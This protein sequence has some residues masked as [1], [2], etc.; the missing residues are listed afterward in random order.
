M[1][2][3]VEGPPV[4]SSRAQLTAE[5]AAL[6][7]AEIAAR[8]HGML[9][10]LTKNVEAV[11]ID[12]GDSDAG[13]RRARELA[14][15]ATDLVT[16]LERAKATVAEH[17]SRVNRL[18]THG[19]AFRATLGHA[20]DA[21]SRDRSRERAHIDAIAARQEGIDADATLTGIDARGRDAL[22][23]EQAALEAEAARAQIV[24]H[25][26]GFQI[27]ALQR[28]LAA[29]NEQLDGE[30]ADATGKLEGALSALRRMTGELIRTI[31]EAA[32][33]VS[34]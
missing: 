20:I 26:I 27:E 12:W 4:V 9:G 32:S 30:L 18:E 19:R 3:H 13:V 34:G 22:V 7:T 17:Q 28:Q 24:E 1:A 23:W 14:G 15:A 29:Q 31:E 16:S 8:W 6:P 5:I 25:D 33:V 2:T 11:A 21:L 10:E